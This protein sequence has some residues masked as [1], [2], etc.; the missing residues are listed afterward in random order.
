MFLFFDL[1]TTGL[2]KSFTAP[3]D[4]TQVCQF[5]HMNYRKGK[6]SRPNFLSGKPI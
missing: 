3:F 4:Q 2:P 6:L 1:E 5:S